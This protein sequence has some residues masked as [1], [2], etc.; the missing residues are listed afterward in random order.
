MKG[1][2]TFFRL[3]K[4]FLSS[5]RLGH[6][7]LVGTSRCFTSDKWN[8]FKNLRPAPV[9]FALLNI[10]WAGWQSY[11][12]RQRS[13]CPAGSVGP[14]ELTS[15]RRR[16][17]VSRDVGTAGSYTQQHH[18]TTEK[19]NRDTN[20]QNTVHMSADYDPQ[21]NTEVWDNTGPQVW[22]ETLDPASSEQVCP[23]QENLSCGTEVRPGLT[24]K[25]VLFLIFGQI[26]LSSGPFCLD[27]PSHWLELNPLCS[28]I[29]VRVSAQTRGVMV[30]DV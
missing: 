12:H 26:R 3:L 8:V 20:T 23:W 10:L 13:L 9:H 6:F 4:L 30:Q 25:Y 27:R 7:W 2:R 29:F 1:N 22:W 21:V 19:H 5:K 14:H 16:T 24:T 11:G 17:C 15:L 18:G 28:I